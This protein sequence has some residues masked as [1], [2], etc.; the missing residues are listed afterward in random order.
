MICEIYQPDFP[1][2]GCGWL[3]AY[4]E[5]VG[6]AVISFASLRH[7]QYYGDFLKSLQYILTKISK[8]TCNI[9]EA[10]GILQRLTVRQ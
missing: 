6:T 2:K 10:K 5:M 7:P 3:T 4:A 9:Q 1:G 8:L